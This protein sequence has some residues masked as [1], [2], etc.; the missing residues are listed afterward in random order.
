M[1][2]GNRECVLV[3]STIELSHSLGYRVVAEGVE[4]IEVADLLRAMGC[5]E[6]Q[7]YWLSRPVKGKAL[8]AWLKK[9]QKTQLKT[10][11]FG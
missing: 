1:A 5:D 9:R 8:F 6:I 2:N 7:G 10:A 4:T 11:I 3:K